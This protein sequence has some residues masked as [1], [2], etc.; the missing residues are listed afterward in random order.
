MSGMLYMLR[1]GC[2]WRALPPVFGPWQTV[3]SRWRLWIAKGVW[4]A[5]IKSLS[6]RRVGVLRFL[7]ASHLKV[8]QDAHGGS[9]GK[10]VQAIG[11]T[12]VEPTPSFTRWWTAGA[13]CCGPHSQ[14]D[15]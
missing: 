8:H 10:E 11:F 14:R 2:P 13:D 15:K 5:A 1:C 9:G 4:S 3:Y 12:R 6:R 7:D